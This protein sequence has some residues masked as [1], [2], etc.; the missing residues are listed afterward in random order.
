MEAEETKRAPIQIQDEEK[1][2]VPEQIDPKKEDQSDD[3]NS[4][5]TSSSSTYRTP[6]DDSSSSSSVT[7]STSGGNNEDS[8]VNRFISS[9]TT[10]PKQPIPSNGVQLPSAPDVKQLPETISDSINGLW[11]P[12]FDKGDKFTIYPFGHTRLLNVVLSRWWHQNTKDVSLDI[13]VDSYKNFVKAPSTLPTH[14]YEVL[15]LAVCLGDSYV[16][17]SITA[18]EGDHFASVAVSDF[19]RTVSMLVFDLKHRVNYIRGSALLLYA[20]TNSKYLRALTDHLITRKIGIEPMTIYE[21]YPLP[22]GNKHSPLW[23]LHQTVQ[24][25]SEGKGII[26]YRD[27]TQIDIDPKEISN[28]HDLK[29]AD[30]DT[31]AGASMYDIPDYPDILADMHIPAMSMTESLLSTSLMHGRSINDISMCAKSNMRN[32]C[33]G[34][35][36]PNPDPLIVDLLHNP[37]AAGFFAHSPY[38]AKYMKALGAIK[39]EERMFI[40]YC[41]TSIAEL[42]N[43]K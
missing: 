20:F 29:P 6:D 39:Q 11:E 15:M 27:G 3:D 42:T 17:R 35:L 16:I 36:G 31:L 37:A 7:N 4:S 18:I 32:F 30:N 10:K 12:P 14:A 23:D 26:V 24:I 40:M 8:L 13:I 1:K 34:L 33:I 43:I 28:E 22:A 5:S 19:L 25:N 21:L 41:C 38:S 9:F 2:S